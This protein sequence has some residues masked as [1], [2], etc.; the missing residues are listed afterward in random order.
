VPGL[1]LNTN[2]VTL[3]AWIRPNGAQENNTGLFTTRAGTGA[4]LTF[5]TDNQIGYLWN[6]GAREHGDLLPGCGLPL[7]SG[8][9]WPWS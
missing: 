9:S 8:H 1:N 3:A 6:N 7:T 4:G 2:T 5:S